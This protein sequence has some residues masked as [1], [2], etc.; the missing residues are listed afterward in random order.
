MSETLPMTKPKFTS[1]EYGK[2]AQEQML[3]Y[4]RQSK[5][6]SKT[7][8]EY[9][10]VVLAFDLVEK[11]V[12][13]GFQHKGVNQITVVD[14]GCS[15][16]L[17]A[18][19]FAR[20]GYQSYGVDFDPAAIEIA[21]K[22]N[23][24]EKTE[25]QFFR[26]DVSDWDIDFPSIDIA[27]CFDLFEHLHDDELGSLFYVLK[28]RLSRHGCIVF[29]TLPQKYDYLF[30]NPRKGRVEFPV[31]LR[32]F[33]NWPFEK[34]RKLVEI[35][36]LLG[37]IINLC[38]GKTTHKTSIKAADHPNPLTKEELV[39]IF[40]RAGFQILTIDSGFLGEIQVDPRHKEQ[41]LRLPITHRSLYGVATRK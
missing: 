39:D 19:E 10:R 16:G 36:A 12:L 23:V 5:I 11:W 27:L 3:K 6:P 8:H 25:A 20:R 15:V 37:D 35:Y 31:G 18:I 22:L 40:E 33:I 9:L 14:I 29:H 38:R 32:P 26:M 13:P 4:Y 34:F 21:Q 24:E 41:F 28:R 7:N 30:W 1:Y 17:F 2:A